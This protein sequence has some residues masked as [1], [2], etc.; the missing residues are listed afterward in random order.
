MRETREGGRRSAEGG[1]GVE[2]RKIFRTNG[3]T[4]KQTHGQT[5]T[6]TDRGSYKGGANLKTIILTPIWRANSDCLKMYRL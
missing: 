4:D 5:D 2:K 1:G 3:H 6:Q